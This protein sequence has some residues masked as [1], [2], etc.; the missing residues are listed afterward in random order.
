[1]KAKKVE[2]WAGF[3]IVRLIARVIY[4]AGLTALIPLIPLVFS[5]GIPRVAFWT[6]VGFVAAGFLL[7]YWF[8]GSR[9]L[10]WRTLGVMTL[11]PGLIA[12][13][14]LFLGPRR[15]ALVYNKLGL[16]SP[17]VQQYIEAYVPHVWFLAGI[18]I[19]LGVVM[20]WLSDVARK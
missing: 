3:F 13:V 2:W 15:A 6:A 7:V 1:M 10:A 16:V 5:H 4:F 18:Y 19:I 17:L 12:V 14:M 20:V 9:K 8:S 11:V